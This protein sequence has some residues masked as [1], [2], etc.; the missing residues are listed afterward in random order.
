MDQLHIHTQGDFHS[1]RE[2]SPLKRDLRFLMANR[3]KYVV[4][5]KLCKTLKYIAS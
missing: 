3:D 4:I 1:Q 2:Y 5:K